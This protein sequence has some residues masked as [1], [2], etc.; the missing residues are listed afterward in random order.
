MATEEPTRPQGDPANEPTARIPDGSSQVSQPP[1]SSP[2]S[3]PAYPGAD[4][5]W[6]DTTARIPAPQQGVPQQGVPQQG[7]YQ[8]GYYQAS[9]Y[10]GYSQPGY[11]QQGYYGQSGPQQPYYAGQ[12]L[13]PQPT[14]P[15]KRRW[16][17]AL[18]ALLLVFS[19]GVLGYAAV[20]NGISAAPELQPYPQSTQT[21]QPQTGPTGTGS[22]PS[23]GSTRSKAVTA[24]QSKGVV[25]IEAETGMSEMIHIKEGV[26]AEH[27]QVECF[28]AN[29]G[30][31]R[32]FPSHAP[33]PHHPR[34]GH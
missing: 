29:N 6:S 20:R 26:A 19:L 31:V 17:V 32:L 15:P 33:S 27:L 9:G 16:P 11:G 13:Y 23:S 5:N 14:P 34:R 25:L 18:V 3:R 28:D 1:Q 30:E 10:Q 2:W 7:Y 8:P 4:Q 12:H 24:A 21:E 22:Q